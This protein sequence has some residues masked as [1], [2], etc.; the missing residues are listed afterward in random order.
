MLTNIALSELSWSLANFHQRVYEDLIVGGCRAQGMYT[1]IF[2]PGTD[3]ILLRARVRPR[4][5][6]VHT[7]QKHCKSNIQHPCELL[8]ELSRGNPGML[9]ESWGISP[10]E[11]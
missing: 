8:G 10:L 5:T 7:A 2:R 11:V 9:H 4:V 1:Y 3:L 6:G